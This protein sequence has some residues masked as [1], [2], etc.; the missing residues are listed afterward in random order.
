LEAGPEC[1]HKETC[2]GCIV[3]LTTRFLSWCAEK[4]QAAGKKVWLLIWDNASWHI[5]KE[6]R[7]WLAHD[8]DQLAEVVVADGDRGLTS[9]DGADGQGARASGIAGD[10]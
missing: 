8:P 4:L 3:S 6:I 1:S 10:G 9:R 2:A 7:R 5:S